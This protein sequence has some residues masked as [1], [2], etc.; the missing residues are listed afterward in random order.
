MCREY[1]YIMI[2]WSIRSK[3]FQ[4]QWS[5]LWFAK[6][7]YTKWRV[8]LLKNL[9]FF[10]I[11]PQW[12]QMSLDNATELSSLYMPRD[13]PLIELGKLMISNY[14]QGLSLRKLLVRIDVNDCKSVTKK[15]SKF[16]LFEIWTYDLIEIKGNIRRMYD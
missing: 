1:T 6:K 10:W 16:F 3:G 7:Y 8:K 2:Q 5:Q 12:W 13:A 4:W 11:S 15:Y 9:S 14:R